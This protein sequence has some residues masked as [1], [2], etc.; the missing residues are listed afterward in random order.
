MIFWHIYLKSIFALQCLYIKGSCKRLGNKELD[1][2]EKYSTNMKTF[3]HKCTE[4]VLD[5][6]VLPQYFYFMTFH[7]IFF[8]HHK[9]I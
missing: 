7:S 6:F 9:S 4:Y 2:L 1:E 3:A 5:N 8:P